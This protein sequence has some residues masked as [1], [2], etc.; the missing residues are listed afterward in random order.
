MVS[1][2]KLSC[3]PEIGTTSLSDPCL[4]IGIPTFNRGSQLPVFFDRLLKVVEPY[5][6]H[7]II[8]VAD[9]SSTDET[10][11]V[12][13]TVATACK[14]VTLNYRRND[15]NIGAIANILSLIEESTTDYFLFLGDDD[16]LDPSGF[17]E[18]IR[19]LHSQRPSALIQSS[20]S[21]T[22]GRRGL[23][24]FEDALT[25]LYEF[26]NSWAGILHA[27]T[28]KKIQGVPRVQHELQS[29]SWPQTALGFMSMWAIRDY[30][31]PYLINQSLGGQ[32][33]NQTRRLETA[34]YWL[35]SLDGLVQA[36]RMVDSFAMN[37]QASKK[38]FR[39]HSHGLMG[40]LRA[41]ASA[42]SEIGFPVLK[43]RQV[44]MHVRECGG[45]RAYILAFVLGRICRGR[46]LR[47]LAILRT[48]M[49]E[50]I[51]PCQADRLLRRR[52][53]DR[54]AQISTTVDQ[55]GH[56]AVDELFRT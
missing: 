3:T 16:F 54:M 39:F 18:V 34:E 40:H 22:H 29:I 7:V 53:K 45:A 24:S 27:P 4:T 12:C 28:A 36:S 55:G 51:T 14:T 13:R 47:Y 49:K 42:R 35:Q 32:M 52:A 48:T 17:A 2:L 30:S 15:R 33:P 9:N 19:I 43:S 26:G 41:I 6:D 8:R 44:E 10:Q 46:T 20:W 11:S 5:G 31:R 1:R 21:H 38:F 23:V 50:A 37:R 25:Y 56:L